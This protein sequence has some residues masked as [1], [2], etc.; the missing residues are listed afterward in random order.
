MRGSKIRA[1]LALAA[2]LLSGCGARSELPEC[3]RGQT[4]PC[5]SFC[6]TGVQACTQGKWTACSTLPPEGDVSIP[7]TVRDFRVDHPDFESDVIGDDPGIVQSALGQD[8]KP[9]YAG[10]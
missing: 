10:S 4:R 8:G 7:S 1:R 6:G 5:E 3:E 9:V 2:V